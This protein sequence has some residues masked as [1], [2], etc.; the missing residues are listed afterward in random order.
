MGQ[1]TSLRTAWSANGFVALLGK[2][3][4]DPFGVIMLYRREFSGSRG[5]LELFSG[6]HFNLTGDPSWSN[7]VKW[8]SEGTDW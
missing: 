6:T 2:S 4:F 1:P 8:N 7:E 3:K 5:D